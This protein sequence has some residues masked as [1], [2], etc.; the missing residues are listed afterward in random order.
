MQFPEL[1]IGLGVVVEIRA[2]LDYLEEIKDA[3]GIDIFTNHGKLLLI[4][5]NDP[6]Y[7]IKYYLNKSG[8]SYGC[9]YK[10]L[11]KLR[12]LGIVKDESSQIDARVKIIKIAINA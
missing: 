9:F 12:K 4:I 2:F 6:G 11:N 8:L 7:P 3:A 5:K 1:L 10:S